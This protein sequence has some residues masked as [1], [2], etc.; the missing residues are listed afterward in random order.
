M[1]VKIRLKRLGKKKSPTYR[2]VV[3]DERRQRESES[4]ESL[5]QY[6]P[7]N[8]NVLF[9]INEERTKYWLSVGAQPTKTVSRLLAQQGILK[10]QMFKSSNLGVSK[11][12]RKKT[13]SD[14]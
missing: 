14:N 4:L 11:K 13:A 6:N 3:M 2:V 8:E 5:G 12:E 7:T 10:K 1:A 9:N